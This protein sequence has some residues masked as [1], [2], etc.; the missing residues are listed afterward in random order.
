MGVA[1]TA[2]VLDQG[3]G[4]HALAGSAGRTGE[5]AN[6]AVVVEIG[7]DLVTELPLKQ[8]RRTVATA[9]AGSRHLDVDPT[10]TTFVA[11]AN[12]LKVRAAAGL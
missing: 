12:I 3:L 1:G 5:R 9:G 10:T 2:V 4:V 11:C 7:R 8:W 6:G